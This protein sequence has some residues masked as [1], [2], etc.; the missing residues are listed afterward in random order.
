M[1]CEVHGDMGKVASTHRHLGRSLLQKVGSDRDQA[2]P[3]GRATWG[4]RANQPLRKHI[5]S[6]TITVSKHK[7]KAEA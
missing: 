2:E 5:Q 3:M 6:Y 4:R 1:C 7:L